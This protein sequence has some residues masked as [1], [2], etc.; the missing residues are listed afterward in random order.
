MQLKDERSLFGRTLTHCLDERSTCNSRTNAHYS[1]ARSGATCQA[2][3]FQ[4]LGRLGAT[5]APGREFCR[6]EARTSFYHF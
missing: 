4:R 3:L 1:I 6:F 2:R 5:G